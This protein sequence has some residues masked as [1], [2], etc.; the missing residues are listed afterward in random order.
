MILKRRLKSTALRIIVCGALTFP[1]AAVPADSQSQTLPVNEHLQLSNRGDRS[2]SANSSLAIGI[3]LASFLY[4]LNPIVTFQNDKIGGGLT[5][6]F[7]VGFGY[8][9]EHR[10]AGEYSY[11]FRSGASSNFRVGYKYDILLKGG[12]RPSNLLQGTSSI[13]LGVS[14]F[15][16]LTNHGISPEIGYGYSIRND[17]LLIYPNLKIRYTHIPKGSDMYDF[18]FGLMVGIANPFIDLNIRSSRPTR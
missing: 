5:K 9:G 7:S 6:E 4:L 12:I 17:K 3:G 1:I 18:S 2:E 14:Y 11:I 15:Y 13:T 16:D 8:F 10:I